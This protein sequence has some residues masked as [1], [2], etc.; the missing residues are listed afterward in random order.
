MLQEV[1]NEFACTVLNYT[2]NKIYVDHFYS[3]DR[4]QDYLTGLN[5]VG[6]QGLFNFDEEIQYNKIDDN[7]L[8]IIQHNGIETAR[9]KYVPLLKATIDYKVS[10]KKEKSINRS[11]TFTL[12]KN[13]YSKLIN[14]IDLDKNSIDFDNIDVLK[15]HLKER[16]GTY[17]LTD[18]SLYCG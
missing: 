1:I 2:N 9:Y 5:C 17:K 18:W 16:Y 11:L 3:E 15:S 4:Y 8:L 7:I 12:R 13:Q 6:G 14:Y 10:V